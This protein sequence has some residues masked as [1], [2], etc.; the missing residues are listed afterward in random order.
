MGRIRGFG[1]GLLLSAILRLVPRLLAKEALIVLIELDLF[2]APFSLPG[3][4]LFIV[5]LFIFLGLFFVLSRI[6]IS[7]LV[8]NLSTKGAGS[9]ILSG[10]CKGLF[11]I[12]LFGFWRRLLSLHSGIFQA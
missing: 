10:C 6:A 1:F 4:F 9:L 11:G 5:V 7:S 8:P 3:I 12:F 2:V